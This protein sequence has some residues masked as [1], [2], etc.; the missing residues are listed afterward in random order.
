MRRF[1]VEEMNAEDGRCTITG[2]EARHMLRVLRMGPG[3][4]FILMDGQGMRFLAVIESAT[5]YEV[6][7]IL[8]KPLPQNPPS[9]VEIVLCQA[10]LKS[11]PMDYLIQKTSELGVNCIQPFT[12]ERTV[13]S[14]HE[15]RVE[16]RLRH[17]RE[18][19]KNAAKQ[20]GRIAP[21]QIFRPVSIEELPAK[22]KQESG[23]KVIFWE[24]EETKHL[25]SLLRDS[26]QAEKFIGMVGPEGGFARK[27][28]SLCRDAGF[29]PVSLGNRILRAETAAITMVAVVQYE[30]GDM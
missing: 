19:A 24:E 28:I 18:I 25:K 22:W 20:S 5:R 11:G 17:W 13:V 8:K 4:H 15:N 1:F 9:P 23:M 21:V 14:L 3:D 6:S 27:E 7:V 30:W 16:N 26:P 10:V 29:V 2:S 12:S